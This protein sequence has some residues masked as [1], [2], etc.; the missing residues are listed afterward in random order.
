MKRTAVLVLLLLGMSVPVAVPQT[1]RL[2]PS[3]VIRNAYRYTISGVAF[4]PDGSRLI[5]TDIGG[6][7]KIWEMPKVRLLRSIDHAGQLLANLLVI[8]GGNSLLTAGWEASERALSPPSTIVMWDLQTGERL[9]TFEEEFLLAGV[10]LD[11]GVLWAQTVSTT[12][13]RAPGRVFA[14]DLNDGRV[15]AMLTGQRAVLSSDRTLVLVASENV[16][17][18]RDSR[19][20]ELKRSI[21]LAARISDVAVL[22]VGRAVI[23]SGNKETVT[24]E[25]R[26]LTS[27]ATIWTK[28]EPRIDAPTSQGGTRFSVFDPNVGIPLLFTSPAGDVIVG[29]R[30]PGSMMQTKDARV[31]D[32]ETGRD[33]VLLHLVGG[34]NGIASIGP[35]AFLPDGLVAI[36]STGRVSVVRLATARVE[37]ELS[38]G[39]GSMAVTPDGAFLATG[40]QEAI[41]LW[42][43]STPR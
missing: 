42:R 32:P 15:N 4:T 9:R 14:W 13:Q 2:D 43:I 6:L 33:R 5:S 29:W 21:P 31:W 10:A 34:R 38:A 40:T 27:G 36:A 3:V 35:A 8:E 18:V 12:S 22:P 16:L 39:A 7:I 28:T 19:T 17:E 41:R 1:Q 30:D 37:R 11:D 25:A 23:S 26:D 24:V 20:T